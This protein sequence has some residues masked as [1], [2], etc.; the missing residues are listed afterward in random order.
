MSDESAAASGERP[1]V[2]GSPRAHGASGSVVSRLNTWQV[3]AGG[4]GYGATDVGGY[5]SQ[6]VADDVGYAW[7]RCPASN[8]LET[9]QAFQGSASRDSAAKNGA[10]DVVPGDAQASRA[11]NALRLSAAS[12]PAPHAE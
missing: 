11:P 9:A 1:G 7:C 4:G 6:Y 3:A 2:L 8:T 5:V 12:Q 10:L